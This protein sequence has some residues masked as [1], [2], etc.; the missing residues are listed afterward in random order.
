MYFTGRVRSSEGT[1]KV[2]FGGCQFW[3]QSIYGIMT[4]GLTKA[5]GRL[6]ELSTTD[7]PLITC[8]KV[9]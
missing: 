4:Y 7:G 9:F 5:N 6:E 1:F 8:T 3:R 2:S